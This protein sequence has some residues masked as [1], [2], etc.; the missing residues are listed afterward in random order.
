MSGRPSNVT[1][2]CE[3]NG[4]TALRYVFGTVYAKLRKC[5]IFVYV[6][7]RLTPY[8]ILKCSNNAI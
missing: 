8:Q 3:K 2:K 5:E 7:I 6:P 4:I 1:L